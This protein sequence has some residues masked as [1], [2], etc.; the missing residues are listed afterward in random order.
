MKE[1]P[2]DDF[3]KCVK[4]SLRHVLKNHDI[5][6]SKI[7][8]VVIKAH[9]I[10]IHTLQFIKLYL[11]EYY[12]EHKKV[13][14]LWNRDENSSRNIYKIAYNAI[15][16]KDRPKYLSR[17]KNGETVISGTTSVCKLQCN[18]SSKKKPHKENLHVL[19]RATLK[20]DMRF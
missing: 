8:D 19:K 7:N 10:V 11:L 18:S 3:F 17:S 5:N 2:L 4:V 12:K 14:A 6:H 9:K 16:K 15:N 20:F 13:P 1:K